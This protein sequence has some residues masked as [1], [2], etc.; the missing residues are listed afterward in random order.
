MRLYNKGSFGSRVGLVALTLGG[1]HLFFMGYEGWL[2]PAGWN[3]GM[4]PVS[5]V[6]F[7]CFVAMYVVN[8]LG[9]E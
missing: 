3:G 8:F 5:L 4:P 1:I 6:A 9:R 2:A 7:T